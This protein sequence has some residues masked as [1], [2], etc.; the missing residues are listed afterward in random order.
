MPAGFVLN[1]YTVV[2]E[3]RVTTIPSDSDLSL[4]C[5]L[6]C[7]V[8]TGVGVIF[9]ELRVKPQESVA[10]FGCGGV[11]L[12]AIQGAALAHADP[13][14]AVDTNPE[15][16]VPAKQFGATHVIDS[17]QEEPAAAIHRITGGRGALYV[18]VAVGAPAAVETAVQA[19]SIPGTVVLVGVPPKG[20]TISVDAFAV[21]LRRTITGSY[22]GGTFPDESIPAYL[23]LHRKGC[24]KLREL[25]RQEYT[26]D[27]INEAIEAMR[28][29]QPG[30]CV[31]R[32]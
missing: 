16:L 25:V 31:I 20:T 9:N 28:A 27:E 8:T 4:A 22:G 12:N 18:V 32:L 11:G 13:I 5:L 14:I 15:S 30:R 23:A 26:L 1:E 3:N 17:G 29:G 24:L 2:S 6:G 21:H 19:T 7:A 10:V